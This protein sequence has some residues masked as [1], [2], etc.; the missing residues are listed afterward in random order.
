MRDE[1]YSELDLHCGPVVVGVGA[2]AGGLDAFCTLL[3]GLKPGHGLAI[4][5]VQHLDPDHESLLPELLSKKIAA[6]VQVAEDGM[7]VESGLIYLIPPGQI[8]TLK[9]G[10]LRL[11]AYSKPR[12]I[13]RP[14]DTFFESLAMDAGA[15]GVGVV[16]SGTGSDG[17]TGVRAI[18]EAGGLVF[19]QDP[20]QAD[21]DGMPKSAIATG[22]GDLVLPTSE[23]IDVINDYFSTRTDL[24]PD[25]LS[26]DEFIARIAKHVCYRTGHDIQHYK[27]STLLRRL[28]VRM[29]VLGIPNPNDYVKE[30]IANKAEAPKLFRDLLINVTSFFRDPD[31]FDALAKTV[32]PDILDGKG[33]NDEVRI[34]VPGC[35]TGQEAFTIAMLIA[36]ELERTCAQPRVSI[37]ATDIDEDAIKIARKGR[38]PASIADEIPPSFLATYFNATDDGYEV[39]PKLREM[40]RFSSQS[41]IKDPPFS[42]VDLVSCRNVAI[43]FEPDLQDFAL[44]VFHYALNEGG[45]L[46]LGPSEMPR[47]S[48]QLFAPNNGR[49]RL[50]RRSKGPA[51]RLNFPATS[52]S[53]YYA[54]T[55]PEDALRQASR[56]PYARTLINKVAPPFVVADK[57][58]NLIYASERAV[59]YFR[60]KPGSTRLGLPQ[61]VVVELEPAVRR[62]IT[63]AERDYLP[64]EQEY[65]GKLA[66]RDVRIV[67]SL[68]FLEDGSRLLVIEDRLDLVEHREVVTAGA[69][70]L[71]DS[72][73]QGLEAELE[74]ARETIRTTVEELETSNEELK[75]SNEEMMSMN[76]ELQSGNEELSTTNEELQSKVAELREANEDLAN[77]MRSTNVITL[78]L[79]DDLRL[80]FFTP[81]SQCVFRF[82]EADRG[83]RI[84]DI[85]GDVDMSHLRARCREVLTSGVPIDE[86]IETNNRDRRYTLKILGYSGDGASKRRGIVCTMTDI[87]E[88]R[89]AVSAAEAE[90]RVSQRS[91]AEIEQLY[92]VSPQAM[93]LMSPDTTYLRVNRQ[94]AEI[95]GRDA[96]AHFGEKMKEIVPDLGEQ[97]DAAFETVLNECEPIVGLQMEGETAAHAGDRRLFSTDWYPVCID[98]EIVAVGVNFRDI[99]E[100]TEMQAELRRM[101]QELQHRV[102]NMLSNVLA[103][104]SRA[105][106]EA[107]ADV[108][109]LDTLAARIRALSQTHKLLTKENWRAADIYALI[110]PELTHVYGVERVN[111]AGPRIELNA[112]A[113]VALGMAIHELATNAVK[114]GAFS[115]G[116]GRVSLN[117]MRIDDGTA[118]RVV[119]RWIESG[120]PAVPPGSG[121]GFGSQLIASTI[122]GSLHGSVET[123]WRPDGLVVEMTVPFETLGKTKE[124]VVY[125]VF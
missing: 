64:C 106:R 103:L 109:V 27:K 23:M 125:D 91:L 90:R 88:L 21:Y 22:A 33:E 119:F 115:Q 92:F 47:N 62:L 84:D 52:A 97:I 74:N 65:R 46:F 107:G 31:A 24:Q 34:W 120:G 93:A 43:Y 63:S 40:I 13:R 113:A 25:K 10:C 36:D 61:L 95:N 123:D 117:W 14:I 45:H 67:V 28:A 82:V 79:D 3:S 112:R 76:E 96:A 17:S 29:S 57:A 41:I 77:L 55:E 12:G 104:V 116:G 54:R 5:L 56:E 68:E 100:Q 8:L 30:L 83:R 49:L 75:S 121:S 105:R 87:T 11:E 18:K 44:S 122:T 20:K 86:E 108:S 2:S 48:N 99:T 51:Q 50:Y 39:S 110:E 4:V 71:D 26:E 58:G 60:I 15:R 35:S 1:A 38:Y 19:V 32:L 73:V 16:L 85:G 42:R 59:P 118:E 6:P 81:A 70:S 124:E 94:M 72:Y 9:D 80:R 101:M 69:G 89:R 114:Y 7:L 53:P 66:G 98:N 111:L 102:K 78:F 37:F